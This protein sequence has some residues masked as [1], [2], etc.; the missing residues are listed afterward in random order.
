MKSKTQL[1]SGLCVALLGFT[2]AGCAA[3]S[4]QTR[5]TSPP[6]GPVVASTTN[7]T[8]PAG[9]ELTIRVNENIESQE[10][11]R[12]FDAQIAQAVVDADGDML[13]PEGARA[14]LVVTEVSDGGVAGTR[15]MMLALQSITVNGQ[16]VEI[17]TEGQQQRGN[18]GL[19]ANR[20]TAEAVGGGAALGAIIGA[21]I[22]GGQGAAAGAAIGAGAG[23]T[24]QVLTR[25]EEVRVP[26]ETILTFRLSQPITIA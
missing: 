24:A 10:A 2:L 13:I 22:G 6:A 15:T 5:V 3:N 11:G 16:N 26:A 18:E 21:A 25:G 14:Q 8:L 9:T 4:Q 1:T 12:T 20:R 17:A 7:G 19:G 23:A